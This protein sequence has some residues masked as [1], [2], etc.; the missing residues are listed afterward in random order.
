MS[1]SGY[2][3]QLSTHEALDETATEESNTTATQSNLSTSQSYDTPSAQH[4]STDTTQDL[5]LSNLTISPSHS[6]PRP[7]RKGQGGSDATTSFA[8]YTSPFEALRAEVIDSG[9]ATKLSQ[10]PAP[11]TPGKTSNT[12]E[13]DYTQATTTPQ[14]SPAL[15]DHIQSIARPSTSRKK[16]DPLLHRVLDR[17]YRIQATPMKATQQVVSRRPNPTATTPV[18]AKSRRNNHRA[19]PTLSSSPAIPAP[20]LHAEIFS[21]PQRRGRPIP[22]I[23]V[24]TPAA[25]RTQPS[26]KAVAPSATPATAGIWDSDDD[27]DD[28]NLDNFG[29]SPPKTMQ[30]HVPQSRLLK[31]PGKS[32]CIS[33]TAASHLMH[34]F[35]THLSPEL[36][37]TDTPHSH[38]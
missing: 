33:S 18:T 10:A 14:S 19:D 3:E 7:A 22:G 13:D 36:N 38:K 29:H 26:S 27:L 5:D 21:S 24:L 32:F 23:S 35:F 12:F 1:L 11:R 9:D 25:K 15:P 20:E 8:N 17:N 30:F 28:S 6:T 34:P 16:T 37:R 2:E 4:I 31:T